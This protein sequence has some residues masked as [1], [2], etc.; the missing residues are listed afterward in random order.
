MVSWNKLNVYV[1]DRENKNH[2]KRIINNASGKIQKGMLIAVMGSRWE[3][4]NI[5][6]IVY[7]DKN[8]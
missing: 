8:L 2:L 6:H 1:K 7:C 4:I 5:I 3:H